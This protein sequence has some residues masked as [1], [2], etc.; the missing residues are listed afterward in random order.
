MGGGDHDV[1][2]DEEREEKM[3][4]RVSFTIDVEAQPIRA[5]KDHID[6]LIWCKI[7]KEG[8]GID[9]MMSMAD[10]HNIRLTLF[11]DYVERCLYGEELLDVG[12]EIARRGHDLQVHMHADFFSDA[13]LTEHQLSRQQWDLCIADKAH[14]SAYVAYLLEAH[15][16]VSSSPPVAYRG[17]GYR[18]G[19]PLLEVLG[20]NGFLLDA[21]YNPLRMK[22][23]MGEVLRAPFL[24]SNG[25]LEVPLSCLTHMPDY[26]RIDYN[27]N[28]T[29]LL[30]N[31]VSD[32]VRQHKM[33][34]EAYF[35]RFGDHAIATLML[36]SWSFLKMDEKGHF[37]M[38]LPDAPARFEA[39]LSELSQE[40]E[41]I[42]LGDLAY[43]LEQ[44]K[45]IAKPKIVDIW[46]KSSRCSICW[47]PAED[48]NDYNG[49][50][51]CHCP[52]CRSMDRHR[53]FMKLYEDGAFGSKILENKH[54][55][56][57]SPSVA[58]R[59]ILRFI[60]KATVVTVEIRPE[61]KTDIV[62]D[63]SNMPQVPTGSF[64]LV[65]VCG[66]FTTVERFQEC[67]A[68]LY[69]VLKPGGVIIACDFLEPNGETKEVTDISSITS[70]YGLENYTNFRVGTFRIFGELDYAEQFSPYFEG[71][72]Y[73]GE[74]AGRR[75]GWFVGLRKAHHMD[76]EL[77][78][79]SKKWRDK[80]RGILDRLVNQSG[81]VKIK[82]RVPMKKRLAITVDVEAREHRAEK[83]HIK[84]LIW[85]NVEGDYYLGLGYM[86][87]LAEKYDIRLTCFLDYAER[88]TYGEELLDVGREIARR[89]HDLQVHLHAVHFSDAFFS[90]RRVPR[91]ND[92]RFLDASTASAYV[93][94]LTEAHSRVSS[95]LPVAFRGGGYFF[96]YP[97]LEALHT[98]GFLLDASYNPFRVKYPMGE[99]LRAPF[100]WSNGIFEVPVPCLPHMLGYGRTD[101]NFNAQ[102][103]LGN[104]IA[105]CVQQHKMFLEAFFQRFGEYAIA[106]LVMHS[107]SFLK[108]D[109]KGHFTLPLPDAPARFEALM[110]ELSQEYEF[111][112]LGDLARNLEKEK[113][114]ANP[115]TLKIGSVFSHCSIC[116]TP[117]E[118]F[119]DYNKGAKRLCPRCNSLERQRVFME[120]YEREVFGPKILENKRILHI[121]PAAAE[122]EILRLIP[123]TTVLTVDVRP[124][125]KTDIVAN[126]SDMP[127]V[128]TGA[129]DLVFASYVFTCTERLTAAVAELWRVLK[130]GGILLCHDPQVSG[131]ITQ[132]KKDISEF[133][134]YYGQDAY[135]L[136]GVGTFR[137][138]G[139][140]D[141]AEQFKPYFE[142]Q[143]HFS[144]DAAT[145]ARIGWFL[146]L[147]K[148]VSHEQ[149][150]DS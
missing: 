77:T 97:L 143:V 56:H 93:E 68:E 117:T 130:Q 110:A 108:M 134:S 121:S 7:G 53:F 112:T 45:N 64:D 120:L 28:V 95:A 44:E 128:P 16:R 74:D 72:I 83:D 131:Q 6:R 79:N 90:D 39:L 126:I 135:T 148:E 85:G 21:S 69:R 26:G 63:I 59:E 119:L 137:F 36:H 78:A 12:R 106:T 133:T 34:L 102:R 96:N 91:E 99:T 80:A 104:S 29:R 54:I 147:R 3:K 87:S 140:L 33:F 100:F 35:Q 113:S 1:A 32:C 49:R 5:E 43:S 46:S 57:I 129:F 20:Q 24:W 116:W 31:S 23:P 92:L 82:N 51:K 22:Y 48:F 9:L 18:L 89:G 144:E 84:R 2:D 107:W 111:I 122:R 109:E 37:T 101:Y 60:P 66:V 139:E 70:W 103:L 94:Y 73:Y 71:K 118:E 67:K 10:K 88:E 40:Y 52:R 124:Q 25:I 125:M 38:P 41:F 76:A 17:G 61:V 136:H 50:N 4:K 58:E 150:T 19:P 42:A 47:T 138:F 141:Y 132:E 98:H 86:M 27:F 15:S 62:A 65:F 55:L 114:A 30:G 13:F 115:K 145:G 123:R 75:I 142:G 11:L 14:C 81:P 127:E 8:L 146:G 149:G 105:N